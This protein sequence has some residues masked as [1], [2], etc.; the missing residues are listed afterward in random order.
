[1]FCSLQYSFADQNTIC[2]VTV[3]KKTD[4]IDKNLQTVIS[5][6]EDHV[7]IRSRFA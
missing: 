7:P 6:N 3:A 5:K 1:M 2:L 4:P